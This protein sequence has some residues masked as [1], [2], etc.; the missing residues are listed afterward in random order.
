MQ[1]FDEVVGCGCLG[2]GVLE[3]VVVVVKLDVFSCLFDGF[4]G[5]LEGEVEILGPDCV[6]PLEWKVSVIR[7]TVELGFTYDAGRESSIRS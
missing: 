5:E 3:T 7:G 1:L 2:T 6:V 4:L